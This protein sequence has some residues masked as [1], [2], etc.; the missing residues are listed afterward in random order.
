MKHLHVIPVP[1]GMNALEAWA[2]IVTMGKLVEPNT[3]DCSWATIECSS[4]ECADIE[5]E[6]D[7]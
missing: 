1:D 3:V 7:S 4:D 5:R 6:C 2:E